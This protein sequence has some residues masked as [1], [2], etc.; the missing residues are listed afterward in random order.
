[1]RRAGA[2]NVRIRQMDDIAE[3][4]DRH[5]DYFDVVLVDAPCSGLGTLRRN[6]G[7]KWL[8]TEE[9]I[10][11]VSQKQLHILQACSELVK[12]GGIVG[13]A[14]C[15]LFREENEDV[16][17][18][19][20]A[21]HPDFSVERPPLDGARLDLAPFMRGGFVKLTPHRD[22]TDGFFIAVLRRRATGGALP[23][24][25]PKTIS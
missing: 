25:E 12:P 4:A 5:R 10:D 24:Q 19:F 8:V 3:L 13:Y 21:A 7:M 1:M 17:H 9:T 11:E 20:L 23:G 15:T 2:S 6:P 16:V 14:T 18:K 22:G